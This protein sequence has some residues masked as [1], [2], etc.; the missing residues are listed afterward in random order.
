MKYLIPY[1]F[2]FLFIYSTSN[3]AN[4]QIPQQISFKKVDTLFVFADSTNIGKPGF[5]KIC[6]TRVLISDTLPKIIVQLFSKRNTHWELK[7]TLEDEPWSS[8]EPE[9]KDF[10]NDGC[11]DFIYSKGT[12]G[13]GGNVIMSLF[14]YDKGGD[15][16][17]YVV[18]S[19]EYPNLYYNKETNSVNSYI[20]TGGNQTVFM[21]IKKNKLQP[22][23]G[24]F[25][26]D[27]VTVS[28]YDSSGNSKVLFVDSTNKYDFF[29]HFS[30]YK[31]LKVK[32]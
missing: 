30:N 25:Q 4:R 5:N 27:K 16:L 15:S 2:I 18:N 14:I 21:R 9:L 12:G 32:E 7:N 3:N 11:K 23:A 26:D 17:I 13:R 29:A 19:N 28:E 6:L 10:N 1:S 22:F 8:V 31:P 20:L 24:I